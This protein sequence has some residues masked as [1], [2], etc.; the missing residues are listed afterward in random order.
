MDL[1]RWDKQWQGITTYEFAIL[2]V[3]F[4]IICQEYHANLLP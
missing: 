4:G 3:P 2:S 1:A